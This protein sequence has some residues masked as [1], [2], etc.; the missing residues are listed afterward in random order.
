MDL[1]S[2]LILAA[3]EGGTIFRLEFSAELLSISRVVAEILRAQ[4]SEP[5]TTRRMHS[6]RRLPLL[7]YK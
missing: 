4:R 5:L 6:P 1:P 2:L 3:L 7:A